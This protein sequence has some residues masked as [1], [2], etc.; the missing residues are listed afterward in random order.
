MGKD[1]EGRAHHDSGE[2]L[3]GTSLRSFAHPTQATPTPTTAGR[4]RTP[5]WFRRARAPSR[6]S[7]GPTIA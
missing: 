6:V 5:F 2:T 4:R 7:P 1:P 3:M